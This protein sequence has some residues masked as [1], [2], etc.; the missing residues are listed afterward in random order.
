MIEFRPGDIF[1]TADPRPIGRAINACERFWEV[2]GRAEYSH[3]GILL[4]AD[5]TTFEALWRVQRQQLS[6]C[7]AH[8]RLLV[9]RHCGMTPK[10]F[11][12]AW[13]KAQRREGRRYPLWRLGLHLVPPLAKY[14]GCGGWMVCSELAAWFLC[15]AGLMDHCMGVTP[16]Y[17]ADAIKRWDDFDVVYERPA[18]EV[19]PS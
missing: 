15:E 16:G 2:D 10:R 13:A 1:C 8:K 17:L 11:E 14:I 18:C 12:R 3:A 5:G 19:V 9:G 7:Y 6:V 4:D